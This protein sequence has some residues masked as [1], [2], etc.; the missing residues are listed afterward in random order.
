MIFKPL[1]LEDM[2]FLRPYLLQNEPQVCNYSSGTF[3]MWRKYH[4]TRFALINEPGFYSLYIK[5]TSERGG[6]AFQLPVTNNMQMAIERLFEE[7]KTEQLS[8][9]MIPEAGLPEFSENYLLSELFDDRD[10]YDYLYNISDLSELHGKRFHGQRNQISQFIRGC[11]SW[12]ITTFD[13]SCRA[14][15]IRFFEEDYMSGVSD[16]ILERS[17][18]ESVREVLNNPDIYGFSGIVLW[19][20]GS[21]AGFSM[22]ERIGDT[23]FVHIEKAHRSV[24]GAYQLLVKSFA[25]HYADSGVRFI[26][27]EDD[28]ADEGLRRSKLSYHPIE[29]IKKYCFTISKNGV[30]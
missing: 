16:G 17:E 19:R 2:D 11:G 13:E 30:Q 12:S 4:N 3:F 21:V 1:E 22:G 24:H 29:L 8:F 25:S 27:R 14:D 9:E 20:D 10:N 7:E 28:S 18:N 23:L 5:I 26:N 6:E 15:V